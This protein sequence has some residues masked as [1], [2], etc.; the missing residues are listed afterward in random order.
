MIPAMIPTKG[1]M[2]AIEFAA[3]EIRVIEFVPNS[4][5][6]QVT[7]AAWTERPSGEPNVVGKFLKD[8]LDSKGFVAKRVLISYS[9]PV[10]EHR[11][12]AIPPVA[13]ENR[14]ELL[15]GKVAQEITTPVGEMR[16]TGEFLGK[17]VEQNVER[18][19]ILTAFVPEFEVKRLIYMLVEAGVS[20]ARVATVPLALA[21]LHP[22]EAKDN[23]A[24]FLHAESNRCVIGVSNA[25]KLRFARE[26]PVEMPT[27]RAAAPP[28]PEV[29]DYGNVVLGGESPTP[30]PAAATPLA[31]LAASSEDEAI[32]ERLV[33]ELTRSLLYF[34]QLSRGGAITKLYWSGIP[35]TP[36][37][38]R[39]IGERLKFTIEPH[40]A[41]TASA[42]LDKLDASPAEYGVP[43]GLAVAMQ[44]AEQ[45][46]LLPEEYLRR[47]KRHKSYA[48]LVAAGILFLAANVALFMGFRNAQG[49]YRALLAESDSGSGR[50]AG[51]EADFIRWSELRKAASDVDAAEK[52]L[53][54]PFT[55]WNDL[56]A[57]LGAS[58]PKEVSFALLSLDRSPTGYNGTLKG[59]SR[60]KDPAQVQERL[61]VFLAGLR[62]R[63]PMLGMAYAP[64]EIRPVR[65]EEG[66][67]YEQ[68]FLVSFTLVR[69]E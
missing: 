19:E 34:R 1:R 62:G 6:V 35:P 67:G 18:H 68:E 23:L 53:A 37:I 14:E 9:G 46:N 63:A 59:L 45:I 25:G 55:R 41:G 27:G 11:I 65:K 47:R 60:G 26:F 43:V 57:A 42:G 33:T 40:P 8:F 29:P 2:L 10:I 49:R 32:A 4:R 54:T 38:E 50:N 17:V 64:V 69:G 31:S 5:P 21:T 58:A 66:K 28:A 15:R 39:L 36:T 61:G 48:A 16:V 7:N 51:M 13:P 20:P 52:A 3:R 24:G 12:Y 22:V 56:F 30:A 44:T